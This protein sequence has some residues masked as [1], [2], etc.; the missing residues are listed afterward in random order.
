[1]TAHS[2]EASIPELGEWTMTW[3]KDKPIR[4]LWV[5]MLAGRSG[6]DGLV[7]RVMILLCRKRRVIKRYICICVKLNAPLQ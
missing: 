7:Q 4:R 1:M 3:F 2:R 6:A 5:E